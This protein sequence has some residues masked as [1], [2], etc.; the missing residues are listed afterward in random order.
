MIRSFLVNQ[1]SIRQLLLLS[2]LLLCANCLFSQEEDGFVLGKVSMDDLEMVVYEP[3]SS[4]SAV[5]LVDDGLVGYEYGGGYYF[6]YHAQI[7]ILDQAAFDLADLKISLYEKNALK[8]FQGATYNL[9]NGRMVA[10]KVSEDQIRIEEEEGKERTTSVTFPNIKVGSIFEYRYKKYIPSPTAYFTWYFQ[11]D[12]PVRYS[13]FSILIPRSQ[14]LQ[15]RIY[16]YVPLKSY[17]QGWLNRGHR[18]IMENIP[19]L[20][21]TEYVKNLDDHF[22]KVKFTYVSEAIDSWVDL[23]DVADNVKSFGTT[24]GKLRKLKNIYPESKGWGAT[25]EDLKEIHAYVANH[26]EW[27]GTVGLT[28]SD[29]PKNAWES[30]SAPASDI[31]LFLLMF[32]RKAGFTA[33]AVFLSTVDHGLI[34]QDFPSFRQ[35]NY[36]V[37]RVLLNYK[38]VLVDATSALRPYNV[39]PGFCLNDMGMV[40]GAGPIEWI[41]MNHN[42]EISNQSFSVNLELD[43][44]DLPELTGNGTANYSQ[45]AAPTM[46]ILLDNLD[47]DERIEVFK[48]QSPDLIIN[49]IDF[50]GMDDAYQSV[51]SKFEFET[52]DKVDEIGGRLFF[53]PV[54]LKEI[55]DNPFTATS[56]ILPVEF[57]MPIRR[58]YFFN[59]SIPEGYEVESLPEAANFVL[60]NGGGN[61]KFI[62]QNTGSSVQ[63]MVRFSINK[64]MFLPSE[65]PAFRELFNLIIAKQ[66]EKVVLKRQ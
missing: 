23:R 30:R 4:A 11:A 21:E 64:L 41:A 44:E 36:V 15:P 17:D 20:K 10:T 61:Y 27:N 45:A 62:C 31:N 3:D 16:G 50:E 49:A 42:G 66:E 12:N 34:N 48:S 8:D 7:K 57:T 52:E 46:R 33:D 19:A 37:V 24:L 65:Y 54:V 25:E 5:V 32:L 22:A 28:F 58:R 2:I 35:F 6:Q 40:M 51:R 53:S 56:R 55:K 63:V 26:F 1:G 14:Y 59:V 60:P 43:L 18:L 29:K 9:E 39:L 38:P 47:E 13:R